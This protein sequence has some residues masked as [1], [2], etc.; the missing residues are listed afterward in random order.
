[1]LTLECAD[2]GK[3]CRSQTEQDLH[4]KRT[5]HSTFRDKARRLAWGTASR[6]DRAAALC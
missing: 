3:P 1:M 6:L 2:C 4:T 5:G